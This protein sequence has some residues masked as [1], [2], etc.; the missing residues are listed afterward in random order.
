MDDDFLNTPLNFDDLNFMEEY[1]LNYEQK[2]K[3]V[4]N[5]VI[6]H[7]VSYLFYIKDVEILKKKLTEALKIIN[8]YK[9]TLQLKEAEI[10]HMLIN[11]DDLIFVEMLSDNKLN[12]IS[13]LKEPSE[14]LINKVNILN[15]KY[16]HLCNDKII[17]DNVKSLFNILSN[18]DKI[19]VSTETPGHAILLET[20]SNIYNRVNELSSGK[21]DGKKRRSKKLRSKKLRSKKLRSKKLRSKKLRSKK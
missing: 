15:T 18:L 17:N 11:K 1:Y 5:V 6:S 21:S 14:K 16:S 2:V 19:I 20:I 12:F 3:N 8:L 10:N 4:I 9:Q 7:I 13:A